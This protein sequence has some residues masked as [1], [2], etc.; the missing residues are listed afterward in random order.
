MY[1]KVLKAEDQL[2]GKDMTLPVNT[3]ASCAQALRTSGHG[4]SLAVTIDAKSAVS[5]P[6]ATKLSVVIKDGDTETGLATVVTHTL[7]FATAKAFTAGDVIA[8][9]PLVDKTRLYTGVA[10]GT[11]KA[12]VTGTVDVFLEYLAR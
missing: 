11:D 3:T 12:G 9:I 2:F 1:K 6:A 4:G 8:R 10:I 5:L 7:E